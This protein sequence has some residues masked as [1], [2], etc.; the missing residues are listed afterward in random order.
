[1]AT[2][3][4]NGAR[5]IEYCRR[6]GYKP[7]FCGTLNPNAKKDYGNFADDKGYW[8]L[9]IDRRMYDRDGNYQDEGEH[10]EVQSVPR[11]SFE[12]QG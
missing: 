3:D 4:V 5:Y 1:M 7:K 8:K 9:L 10:I 6:M 12:D 2:A 11:G